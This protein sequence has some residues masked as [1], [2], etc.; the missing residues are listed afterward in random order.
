MLLIWIHVRQP[1]ASP[2]YPRPSRFQISHFLGAF[3]SI[4]DV[5]VSLWDNKDTLF[6][7]DSVE[8]SIWRIVTI[9]RMC[10]AVHQITKPDFL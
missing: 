4:E 2:S 9:E 5:W 1:S 10:A 8:K 6:F 7:G 3:V